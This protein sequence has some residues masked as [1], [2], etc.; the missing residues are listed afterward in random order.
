[1]HATRLV[2]AA[3]V[4]LSLGLSACGNSSSPTTSTA[5][6]PP[7]RTVSKPVLLAKAAA[8]CRKFNTETYAIG[9]G[10]H[11]PASRSAAGL[12][13]VGEIRKH[14]AQ[15]RAV[16]YPPGD[17]AR[18]QLLYSGMDR[19]LAKLQASGTGPNFLQTIKSRIRPYTAKLA[20]YG[21]PC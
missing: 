8:L 16:G 5:A 17:R 10:A 13:I 1:M 2:L 21:I 12:A 6:T 4:A 19:A 11:D 20:A 15:L 18:L 9:A 7:V 3:S 14:V